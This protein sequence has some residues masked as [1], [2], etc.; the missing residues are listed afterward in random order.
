MAL[1][2]VSLIPLTGHAQSYNALMEFGSAQGGTS[3]VWFYQESDDSTFANLLF[4]A[5]GNSFTGY[6]PTWQTS[7][8]NLPVI[9]KEQATSDGLVFHPG[10]QG[11]G[12]QPSRHDIVLRWTAPTS[13]QYSVEGFVRGDGRFGV[14]SAAIARCKD[15]CDNYNGGS[16]TGPVHCN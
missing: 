3:G 14:G 10:I 8:H 2:A 13:G 15:C 4:N 16:P 11:N 9:F 12:Q 1:V 7:G 5:S 6:Q